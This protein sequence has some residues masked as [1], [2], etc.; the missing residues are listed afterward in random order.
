[1]GKI[2]LIYAEEIPRRTTN[3]EQARDPIFFC[4]DKEMTRNRETPKAKYGVSYY[5]L[6]MTNVAIENGHL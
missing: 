5:P 2:S 1:M 4:D 6:V 3:I